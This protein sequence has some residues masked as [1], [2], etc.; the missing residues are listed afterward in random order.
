MSMPPMT[1]SDLP[2]TTSIPLTDTVH[3]YLVP[4]MRHSSYSNVKHKRLQALLEKLSKAGALK[5]D[6]AV[7]ELAEKRRKQADAVGRLFPGEGR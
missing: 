3:E 2:Q 4:A 6:P 1:R 7:R 5:R